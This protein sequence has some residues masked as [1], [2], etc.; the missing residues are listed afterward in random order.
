MRPFSYWQVTLH[1]PSS[2]SEG[3]LGGS[4][5]AVALHLR[6]CLTVAEPAV[7]YVASRP[8]PAWC[9]LHVFYLFILSSYVILIVLTDWLRDNV[10]FW[11]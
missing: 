11:S 10:S 9:L 1:T 3:C 5:K 6:G 7:R 4:C 2:P 8:F